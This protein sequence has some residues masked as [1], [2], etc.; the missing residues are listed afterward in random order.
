L[1]VPIDL[2]CL[3]GRCVAAGIEDC[4]VADRISDGIQNESRSMTVGI[5]CILLA[6]LAD[7]RG[8]GIECYRR[9]LGAAN[10]LCILVPQSGR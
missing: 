3:V 7:K 6:A 10:Q 2:I 9:F 1:R 5:S 8:L 4:I